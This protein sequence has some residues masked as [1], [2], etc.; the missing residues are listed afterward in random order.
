MAERGWS[1]KGRLEPLWSRLKGRRDEL[2][3][4]TGIR[5]TMLS[6]YNSGKLKLGMRNAVKIA[7]ALGV[8]VYDLGAPR[9][10]ERQ[11][12][13]SMMGQILTELQ[14]DIQ[15][16]DPVILRSLAGE[17]RAAAAALEAVAAAQADDGPP[18]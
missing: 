7:D 5:G 15:A 3:D 12:L 10:P 2:A 9:V 4:L 14:R 11:F 1:A 13:V 8:S 18:A 6:G 16:V 17:F